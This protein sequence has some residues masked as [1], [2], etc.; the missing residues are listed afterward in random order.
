MKIN[1]Y[2]IFF[3]V[4]VITTNIGT[5]Q[6]IFIPDDKFE[7]VLIDLGYDLGPLND[8][9]LLT[10][11]QNIK[12]LTV[13][14]KEVQDLK[15]IENFEYLE[16]L[17][18]NNNLL[19]HL[20]LSKNLH[21]KKIYCQNNLLTDIDLGDNPELNYLS[22]YNN[23]ITKLELETIL[24]LQYLVCNR[25]SLTKLN[26]S[27]NK[28]LSYLDASDNK[29]T[30]LNIR[31][32]NNSNISYLNIMSNEFLYCVEVDDP[33]QAL[34]RTNWFR[35]GATSYSDNCDS[36][37]D[38][39]TYVPDDNFEQML[40]S[41][42][43]DYPGL[44]DSVPTDAIKFLKWL[45]VG[46]SN[47]SDLT[48]IEAFVSLE[49][50]RCSYN[51]I[52]TLE[53][54][55]NLN[56]KSINCDHNKLT[57]LDLSLNSKLKFLYANNNL[58]TNINLQNGNNKNMV[59]NLLE[60]PLL[61]CIQVDD[62]IASYENPNWY[63]SQCTGYSEDCTNFKMQMTYIHD[64]LFEKALISR[65]IDCGELNDSVPTLAIDKIE[66]LD[67][68]GLGIT[69][70]T[71]IEDFKNLKELN[72]QSN[73]L[74]SLDLRINSKLEKL[75]CAYNNL[76]EL[77]LP[78]ENLHHIDCSYNNLTSIDLS[79]LSRLEKFYCNENKL[80]AL[81]LTKNESLTT[82]F[83]ENNELKYLDLSSNI[84]LEILIIRTNQL[85]ILDIS[86]N[87][88][89]YNLDCQ[90]NQL[91]WL[92][93]KNGHNEI[94]GFINANYNPDLL[95]IQVDD[96]AASYEKNTWYRNG[97]AAYSKDCSNNSMK[98]TY[99]P[100]DGFEQILI[101]LGYD[102]GELNDSVPS[103]GLQYIKSLNIF[104]Q[105]ISDLTGI[106][107]FVGLTDL[108]CD[109]NKLTSIDLSSLKNL[110]VL[111]CNENKLTSLNLS[112][113]INL[114][115]LRCGRNNLTNLD[116]SSNVLLT[117]FS[118]TNNQ[119]KNIDLKNNHKL[120]EVECSYNFIDKLDLSATDSLI[121][122]YCNNNNLK[123]LNLK[124]GNNDKLIN[125]YCTDNQLTCI[126]VDNS[127]GIPDYYNWY[128]DDF[129]EYS[130][131]CGFS[132]VKVDEIRN[133]IINIYPN[134]AN[135]AVFVETG[136]KSVN[137]QVYNSFGSLI[138]E[139]NNFTSDW[140][141]IDKFPI[142]VYIFRFVDKSFGTINKKTNFQ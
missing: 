11:I 103:F 83:C 12:T 34:E 76:I 24:I 35:N 118:C 4:F 112:S 30:S 59:V 109:G 42:G 61:T 142:G 23:Q 79:H 87:P 14:Y 120:C 88:N 15:G 134:P 137:L 104:N 108:V 73:Y 132:P 45:D 44:N 67:L 62:P 6:N 32:G 127:N 81:D 125:M 36:F 119:I 82:L 102:F 78:F 63:K 123:V 3:V 18:C 21:L 52:E 13:S 129:A 131:D 41:S 70:L 77:Q 86:K 39:M 38:K 16:V 27:S 10:S 65:G 91:S 58:L 43:L 64:D 71:G 68:S 93:L 7:Q 31:N 130:A 50:L 20:D 106:E 57:Q 138:L 111:S 17:N 47:I 128:K 100:D 114:E 5:S 136:N 92:N 22:C 113:N 48:G 140:I 139:K 9:I 97:Y 55:S 54:S 56:L 85:T 90:M 101:N 107:A 126:Q 110:K 49:D 2:L 115:Y 80:N 122:L 33:I 53:L 117:I 96:P 141:E 105:W 84:N 74:D 89:I 75:Y 1:F 8:S 116:V 94:L 95:C 99:V 133:E 66:M 124:N 46:S 135:Q 60:N 29:L 121:Y 69:D 19:T 37:G 72:C 40:I 26:L 28:S 98:M 25:N 51:E